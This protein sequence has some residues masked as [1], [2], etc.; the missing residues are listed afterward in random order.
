MNATAYKNDKEYVIAQAKTIISSSIIKLFGKTQTKYTS[1]FEYPDPIR[2]YIRSEYSEH[3]IPLF[4]DA[5]EKKKM[6]ANHNQPGFYENFTEG[7]KQSIEMIS[8]EGWD[9]QTE[10]KDIDILIKNVFYIIF[11]EKIEKK[12][13]HIDF[14]CK[15]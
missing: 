11:K 15:N 12:E 6:N 9:I 4:S 13:I 14:H 7:F 10:K 5:D 3:Q 2:I 8:K 1:L